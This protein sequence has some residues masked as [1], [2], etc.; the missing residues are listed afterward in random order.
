LPKP[1]FFFSPV[2]SHPEE[3]TILNQHLF[4]PL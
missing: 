2:A 4:M 1:K 3:V